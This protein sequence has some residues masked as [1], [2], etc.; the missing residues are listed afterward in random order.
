MIYHTAPGNKALCDFITFESHKEAIFHLE[1]DHLGGERLLIWTTHWGIR[2]KNNEEFLFNRPLQDFLFWL[3]VKPFAENL[4]PDSDAFDAQCSWCLLRMKELCSASCWVER[5]CYVLNSG[6]SDQ[7]SRIDLIGF[8]SATKTW[9]PKPRTDPRA[10]APR[11]TY[12]S[13]LREG[14]NSCRR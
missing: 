7:T 2:A 4:H 10:V 5:W 3:V 1:V 14:R 9:M 6:C 13:M 8:S 12:Y 11:R